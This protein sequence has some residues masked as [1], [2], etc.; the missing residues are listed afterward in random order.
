M[1]SG[2]TDVVPVDGQPWDTTPFVATLKDDRLYGRGVADMKSFSAIALAFVPEFVRRGLARPLHFAFSYDEE[3]GCIGV[4]R[5]IDDVV[6]KGMEARRMHRR[7]ADRHAARRRAQG[8]D[9]LALPRART[10][11]AFVADAAWA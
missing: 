8:Q 4:R 5:L 7:R 11:G 6:R 10:R 3:I 2:H 1:L 9:E